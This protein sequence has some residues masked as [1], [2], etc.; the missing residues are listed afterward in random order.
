VICGFVQ[1]QKVCRLHERSGQSNAAL[2]ASAHRQHTI[3]EPIT[4]AE[5]IQHGCGFPRITHGLAGRHI[6]EHRTLQQRRDGNAAFFA[7]DPTVG[8]N[9]PGCNAE[10]C[11]LT[12]AVVA[13]DTKAVTGAD[14]QRDIRENL[15]PGMAERHVV[16]I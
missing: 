12:S 8:F 11:R 15:A 13:N 14:G 4:E 1:D 2:F 7:H 10:K 9:R 5:T 16:N 6:V 3:A